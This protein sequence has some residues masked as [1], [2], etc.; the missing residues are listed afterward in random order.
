MTPNQVEIRQIPLI[1]TEKTS[2]SFISSLFKSAATILN[3][4][5]TDS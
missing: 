5:P 2:P 3:I 4:S 1:L